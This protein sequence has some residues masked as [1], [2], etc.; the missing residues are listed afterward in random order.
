M[1][2]F[3]TESP[4]SEEEMGEV[5]QYAEVS[6]GLWRRRSLYSTVALLASF[7]CVDPFL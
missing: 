4:L 2:I 1:T 7:A 6:I 5:R 3:D